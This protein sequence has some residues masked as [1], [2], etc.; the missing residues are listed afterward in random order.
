MVLQYRGGELDHF[1]PYYVTVVIVDAFEVVEV[2]DQHRQRMLGI[3]LRKLLIEGV[4][5][6]AAVVETS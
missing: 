4:V 1:I 5:E 2:A 3:D 6:E